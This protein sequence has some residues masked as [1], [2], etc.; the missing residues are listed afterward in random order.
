MGVFAQSM[1]STLQCNAFYNTPEGMSHFGYHFQPIL[2]LLVPLFWIA[3]FTETLLIAQSIALGAAS[4][5]LYRLALAKGLGHGTALFVQ[6]LFTLSPLVHGLNFFDFHPVSFAVPLVFVMLLGLVQ[7][8]WPIFAIGLFLALM[9]KEDVIAALAVFGAVMLLAQY[10]KTKRIRKEYLAVFLSSIVMGLVAIIVARKASGMSLP[11]M[12]GLG[13]VR[14]LWV[15]LPLGSLI[16]QALRAFFQWGSLLL[17]I[18]YLWPLGFLP[19]LA[20]LWA[21]PA[22]FILAKDMFATWGGQKALYQYPAPAIPFLFMALIMTLIPGAGSKAQAWIPKISKPLIAIM[23]IMLLGLDFLLGLHPSSVF[24]QMGIPDSH[25]RAITAIINLIPDG[26]SVTAPNHIF[27]HLCTRTTTYPPYVPEKPN[28]FLGEFGLLEI[29]TEY[30]I[31]DQQ[32]MRDYRY[33]QQEAG[34][35]WADYIA[36]KYGL[37][38][39]IDGVSLLQRNYTDL[40]VLTDLNTATGFNVSIYQDRDFQEEIIK[41]QYFSARLKGLDVGGIIPGIALPNQWSILFEG[42]VRVPKDARY[43]LYLS[44]DGGAVLKIDGSVVRDPNILSGEIELPLTK[45]SHKIELYYTERTESGYLSLDLDG[46]S[47]YRSA[48]GQAG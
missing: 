7:R 16:V 46:L 36:G 29:D 19:L 39:H 28:R 14:Y 48:T 40:P 12:L 21:A 31:L 1:S 13:E 5:L 17:F 23:L 8:R 30:V 37:L 27:S 44:S 18:S 6:V 34:V 15:N 25:S 24:R 32:W 3:P 9:T 45:G 41:A 26:A 2:F 38:A 43:G 22:L 33:G 35:N 42:Y 20:P 47:V 4:Y 10:L 11:P